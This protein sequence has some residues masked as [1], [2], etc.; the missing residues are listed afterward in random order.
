MHISVGVHIRHTGVGNFYN[1][2]VKT[3]MQLVITREMLI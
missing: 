1:G 2:L 3:F